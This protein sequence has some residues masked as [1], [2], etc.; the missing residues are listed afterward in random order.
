MLQNIETQNTDNSVYNYLFD[1]H[2][3]Y[4]CIVSF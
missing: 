1:T 4:Q 2:E 3:Q